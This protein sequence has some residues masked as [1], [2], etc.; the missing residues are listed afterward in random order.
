MFVAS[1]SG[2]PDPV[3]HLLLLPSLLSDFALAA[4]RG[5]LY[6]ELSTEGGSTVPN[7]AAVV[8][9]GQLGESVREVFFLVCGQA[10]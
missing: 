2:W 7:A 1:L 8:P 9:S 3:L 6:T 4:A 10:S 5:S